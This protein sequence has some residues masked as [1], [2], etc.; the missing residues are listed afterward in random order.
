MK[1]GKVWVLMEGAVDR[2][3]GLTNR[4]VGGRE[5]RGGQAGRQH[6]HRSEITSFY[7]KAP[8]TH[9]HYYTHRINS[10]LR[11][12]FQMAFGYKRWG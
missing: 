11:K 12:T 9:P 1:V 2:C 8:L 10:I 3:N 6:G 5:A 7:L 4:Q